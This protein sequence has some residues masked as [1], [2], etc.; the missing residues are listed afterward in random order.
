MQLPMRGPRTLTDDERLII[1]KALDA[2]AAMTRETLARMRTSE[3]LSRDAQARQRD[4]LKV[5]AHQQDILSI[6]IGDKA[7]SVVL[8][9]EGNN[10]QGV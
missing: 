10:R 4:A 1:R 9:A 6:A 8:V 5:L 2:A 3:L 7:L